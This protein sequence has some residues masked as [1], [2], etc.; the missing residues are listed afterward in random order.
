MTGN[1]EE[2]KKIRNIEIDY[3]SI[4]WQSTEF[5]RLNLHISCFV[6]VKDVKLFQI[7]VLLHLSNQLLCAYWI[8]CCSFIRVSVCVCVLIIVICL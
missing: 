3:I 7:S 4:K 6:I 1:R 5:R 8:R 2:E